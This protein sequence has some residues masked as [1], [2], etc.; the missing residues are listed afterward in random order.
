MKSTMTTLLIGWPGSSKICQ[1]THRAQYQS[2]PPSAHRIRSVA[3]PI[4]EYSLLKSSRADELSVLQDDLAKFV[5]EPTLPPQ[6]V[7]V[8]EEG[9]AKTKEWCE[10]GEGDGTVVIEDTSEEDD[11]E[12]TLQ[13]ASSCDQGLAALDCRTFLS[14]RIGLA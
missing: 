4:V 10:V 6:L 1:H 5:S 8:P 2:T 14:F 11:D 7:E 12:E 3:V 13:S 9:R